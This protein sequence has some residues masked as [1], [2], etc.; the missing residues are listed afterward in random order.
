MRPWKLAA[1]AAYGVI[2]T[3][4]RPTVCTRRVTSLSLDRA[5]RFAAFNGHSIIRNGLPTMGWLQPQGR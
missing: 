5:R 2:L 4:R 3:T 1:L